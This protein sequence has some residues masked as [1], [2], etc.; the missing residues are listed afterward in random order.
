MISVIVYGRNDSHGYNL[1]KRA[2][3]S[4]NSL[5]ATLTHRDDEILFVDWNSDEHLPPFPVAIGDCLTDHCKSILRIISVPRFVHRDFVRSR[6]KK[7]TVEPVARNVGI[8]RA[9]PGN[10]WIL[11]T[12]TDV[13]LDVEG[14]SLSDLVEELDGEY[15]ATPRFE[16]PEWVWEALPRTD[17]R[18]ASTALREARGKAVPLSV[19]SSYPYALFDAPGDFQLFRRDSLESIGCF[20]ETMIH[21]WHVDSN[22]AVR[23]SRAFGGP[24]SLEASVQVFHCNHTRQTTH[25]HASASA[26]NDRAV[27]VFGDVPALARSGRFDWG[28]PDVALASVTLE[29]LSSQAQELAAGLPSSGKVP[30]R[31]D[32]TKES[33]RLSG[34]PA[35]VS[36]PFLLDQIL[37]SQGGPVVYVGR[38]HEMHDLLAEVALRLDRPFGHGGEADLLVDPSAPPVVIVDLTPPQGVVA[39]TARTL[40]DLSLDDKIALWETL[41]ELDALISSR[42]WA[43]GDARYLIIN[44]EGNAMERT[45]LGAFDMLPSQFYSRVRPASLRKVSESRSKGRRRAAR[46]AVGVMDYAT[47][48]VRSSGRRHPRARAAVR[49]LVTP[50]WRAASRVDRLRGRFY[51]AIRAAAGLLLPPELAKIGPAFGKPLVGRVALPSDS[52]GHPQPRQGSSPGS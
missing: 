44:A 6:T 35:T 11:S 41:R 21:G 16:L 52:R 47:I 50:L 30:F 39:R 42:D 15:Y 5:A 20:D 25:W 49:P 48:F 14:E 17:P 10:P 43:P 8:R 40:A 12:N 24:L 32:Y 19:V 18:A 51:S 13:L 36:L 26:G 4:L 38:R 7:P 23:M 34:V 46:L 9:I 2:T 27:Y 1:H 29:D 45:L 28:L 31:T 37:I 22:M 3:L 33:E